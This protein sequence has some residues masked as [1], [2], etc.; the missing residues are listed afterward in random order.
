[1]GDSTSPTT[2]VNSWQ[3]LLDIHR[4]TFGLSGIELFQA[5]GTQLTSSLSADYCMIGQMRGQDTDNPCIDTLVVATRNGDDVTLADNFTYS[6]EGTPCETVTGNRVCVVPDHVAEQ[7][8]HDSLLEEM[9]LQ[10]YIGAPLYGHGGRI[11]GVVNLL[12]RRTL[13]EDEAARAAF[14]L[15]LFALR[16][17]SELDRQYVERR[18]KRNQYYAEAGFKYS[19][20]AMLLLDNNGCITHANSSFRD[21]TGFFEDKLR[22]KHLSL[23]FAEEHRSSIQQCVSELISAKATQMTLETDLI[24]SRELRR[25]VTMSV[26]SLQN[27]D[28]TIARLVVQLEDITHRKLA[29]QEISKLLQSIESSPVAT[30]ITDAN[31]VI[32]YVNPRYTLLSGFSGQEAIGKRTSINSSGETPRDVYNVM[33]QNIL[34]GRRWQGELLNKRKDGTTYWARTTIFPIRDDSH[35]ITHFVSLQEDV[36]EARSLAQ[37][38]YHQATHDQL[39]GLINRRDFHRRLSQAIENAIE[40]DTCHSLC[41]LDMDQFKVVNDTS[42]HIAGD[43]L[44]TRIGSTLLNHVRANDTAARVGGDEFALILSNCPPE[45]AR[46][47]CDD[48][49]AAVMDNPFIW[50]DKIYN[51]G[52]SI[53]ITAITGDTLDTVELMKQVDTACYSAKDAG[54]NCIAIY[55]DDDSRVQRHRTETDW[56]PQLTSALRNRRFRL[57]IQPIIPLRDSQDAGHPIDSPPH[58]EV[59]I[60]LLDRN[61]NLVSP[62]DFMPAAERYGLAPL[63]DRTVFDTTYAFLSEHPVA[64]QQLGSLSIN[65]SGASISHSEL[66]SHIIKVI[67]EGSV[68]PSKIQFEIT[69]TAAISNIID[70]RNFM[71]Q[72]RAIGCRILLDD[73]G[74]GLSSF[75]YLKNLPV[76]ALKIDGLF[77]RGM[78]Q[79]QADLA[80]VRMINELAHALGIKTVAEFIE[81]QAT[82][83]RVQ[84]LGI[85]YAQGYHIAR[86]TALESI[87]QGFGSLTMARPTAAQEC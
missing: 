25:T 7:Y 44:L 34:S 80:M 29:E 40:N 75:A 66:L 62:A 3:F 70:A 13:T 74:R 51:V 43:A 10:A 39:T 85:D 21:L 78:L 41:F 32:E 20:L 60:R 30:V 48:I 69:E 16:C 86:P 26:Y 31:G 63:L 8:P 22:G 53:G 46:E 47:I 2:D 73:F 36:S 72:L 14:V 55:R 17:A 59:L 49:R 18:I 45:K 67:S 87:A 27:T 54:R 37:K 38:L 42:G 19:P 83:D 81:E 33:W 35:N 65:L 77:I 76:D 15:E 9:R 57:H 61:N 64:T 84:A 82:L 12:F 4:Q 23:Y 1:M 50:E 5:L 79:D 71:E 56:V 28:G 68:E 52:V 6:L 24:D 58:F 11:H